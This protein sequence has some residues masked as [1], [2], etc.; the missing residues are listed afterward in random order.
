MTILF[1]LGVEYDRKVTCVARLVAAC[2]ALVLALYPLAMERCRTACATPA[3]AAQTDGGAASS[4]RAC[5]ETASGAA[6]VIATPLPRTCGHSDDA[7]A[8]D[9]ATLAASRTRTVPH[10]AVAIL[11]TAVVP[12]ALET[13]ALSPPGSLPSADRAALA[14]NLPL[15]L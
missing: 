7:A 2:L 11:S 9:G 15:R 8:R 13:L 3:P 12:V 1:A 6:D 4:A 5:H 14:R 10:A